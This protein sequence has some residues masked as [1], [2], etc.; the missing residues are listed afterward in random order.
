MPSA[1][2]S[3]LQIPAV[4]REFKD[5]DRSHRKLAHR[6]CDESRVWVPPSTFRRVLAAN[7]GVTTFELAQPVL[8]ARGSVEMDDADL[9]GG[10][11]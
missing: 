10:R 8:E 2:N 6:S 7:E 4:A 9:V 11:T 3:S 1:L 5:I